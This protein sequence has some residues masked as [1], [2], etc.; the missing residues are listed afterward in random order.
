[1]EMGSR[2]QQTSPEGDGSN[3]SL[4]NYNNFIADC[5]QKPSKQQKYLM[6][7]KFANFFGF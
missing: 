7:N 4:T 5:F 2:C 1:M 3:E 6:K